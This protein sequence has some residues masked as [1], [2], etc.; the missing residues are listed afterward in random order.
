MKGSE[1][2]K[3][4]DPLY[5]YKSLFVTGLPGVG[6]T[7]LAVNIVNKYLDHDKKC[8]VLEN[9][10]FSFIDYIDRIKVIRE[11]KFID[12]DISCFKKYGN[13]TVA[14]NYFFELDCVLFAVEELNADVIVY[15]ST[16]FINED[17][18]ALIKLSEELKNQG[19]IFIFI[20]HIKRRITQ[21]HHK[22][23]S[24][25][26]YSRYKKAIPH[27]DATAIVFRDINDDNEYIE[28]IRI[29][30]K[31]KKKYHATPVCFDFPNHKLTL[32]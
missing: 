25:P 13:L 31:D 17:T 1:Q 28:E 26:K 16:N 20:T 6:L 5:P 15:E 2:M 7:T 4:K 30:E 19:K 10:N 21:F 12:N 23:P 32:K 9:Q 8:L 24:K 14:Q 29:Y 27:F 22:A 3:N 18:K 11:N